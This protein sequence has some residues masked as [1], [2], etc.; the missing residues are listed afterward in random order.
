MGLRNRAKSAATP[1]L[2]SS[3]SKT[4]TCHSSNEPVSPVMGQY[5]KPHAKAWAAKIRSFDGYV[6]VTPE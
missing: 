2:N 1:S 4:L 3:T 5:S 6:L